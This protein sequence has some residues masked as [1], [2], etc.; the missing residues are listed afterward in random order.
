M[1]H[2]TGS[3]LSGKKSW[4]MFDDEIVALGSDIQAS[5][6]K[7]V[8]TIVENRKVSENAELTVNGQTLPEDAN[9]SDTWNQVEWAHLQGDAPGTDIGYYFPHMT[10]LTAK[11][12]QRQGAW[13]DINDN[14]SA[15]TITQAYFSMAVDH[16]VNPSDQQYEYVLLPNYSQ[17]EMKDYAENPAV[18]I[19]ENSQAAHGVYHKNLRITGVNFWEDGIHTVGS[20]TANA[21]ASVMTRIVNDELHISLTD[22]TR[23]NTGTIELEIDQEALSVLSK[24][25]RVTVENLSP[26]VVLKFDVNN[27]LGQPIEAVLQVDA[28]PS[29]VSEVSVIPG[30]NQLTLQWN[31]PADSDLRYIEIAPVDTVTG[32][33]YDL[34]TPVSVT[35]DVYEPETPSSV[36]EAVYVDKGIETYTF[37]NLEND[38][39]YAFK[40]RAIDESG[41]VSEGIV[42]EGM[43]QA[44]S[45]EPP[46]DTD[47]PTN[48]VQDSRD[49]HTGKKQSVVVSQ[50]GKIEVNAEP[51]EGV[52][53]A[54]VYTQDVRSALQKSDTNQIIIKLNSEQATDQVRVRIPISNIV[55]EKNEHIQTISLNAGMANIMVSTDLLRDYAD[56]TSASS[57]EIVFAKIPVSNGNPAESVID[58]NLIIG[59][60]DLENLEAE[61]NVYVTIPYALREHEQAERIVVYG[62]HDGEMS[63]LKYS[64]FN[65]IL[66]QVEFRLNRFGLHRIG[67]AD[68]DFS[69]VSQDWA[70]EAITALSARG[71]IEGVGEGKFEPDRKVTRA[72][73]I[74]MMMNIIDLDLALDAYVDRPFTDVDS[75]D[76]YA[77]AVGKAKA[78]GIIQGNGDGTFR[79]DETLTR[80]DMAVMIHRLLQYLQLNMEYNPVKPFEDQQ[81]ISKYALDSVQVLQQAGLIKG[82]GNGV[83][84]PKS[85]TTRAQAAVLM[86]SL[87]K[88]LF[89][90][91]SAVS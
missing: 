40:L 91:P 27:A 79:G 42:V 30:D 36:T 64:H 81:N 20:L 28:A 60:H 46:T 80:E 15:D 85:A 29:D 70:K 86:H 6:G 88:E 25:D 51:I 22:P 57:M 61:G 50:D 63:V 5:N 83:F 41:N 14:G 53:K 4:F 73:F 84:S 24:D 52:L 1:D 49:E 21:K 31:D 78:L 77:V 39:L 71:M 90:I 2:V 32:S 34:V 35:T 9:W 12:E 48:P 8:E 89:K 69:D 54:V 68:I 18:E 65:P 45:F 43:P 74:Q 76:W 56:A 3:D 55:D 7:Q 13:K 58:I 16:G 72:E 26:R 75:H 62:E 37:V 38:K 47:S 59:K 17:E 87:W 10:D 33:V 67:Y 23:K 44:G 82:V 66:Q 11:R 19:L